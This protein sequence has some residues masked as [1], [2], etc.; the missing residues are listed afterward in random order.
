MKNF[1]E[2]VSNFWF[3]ISASDEYLRDLCDHMPESKYKLQGAIELIINICFS[4]CY[5][6]I[7][8]DDNGRYILILS[9]SCN[10][11]NVL[12]IRYLLNQAPKELH[13]HWDFY[14]GFPKTNNPNY[15][16]E[17]KG[18]QFGFHDLYIYPKINQ[19]FMDFEVY[20]ENFQHLDYRM[21]IYVT[22]D[23]MQA[24]LGEIDLIYLVKHVKISQEKLTDSFPLDQLPTYIKNVIQKEQWFNTENPFQVYKPYS[25]I[26]R[27]ND[28]DLRDDMYYGYSTQIKLMNE[29]FDFDDHQIQAAKENGI[30]VGFIFYEHTRISRNKREALREELEDKITE[31]CERKQIAEN[32]GIAGGVYYSY[33]DYVV[34]DWECFTEVMSEFLADVDTA[35]YGFHYFASK[36]KPFYMVN[37]AVDNIN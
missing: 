11:L 20:A 25:T 33:I 37:K 29:V 31:A 10:P 12:Y 28:T 1:K 16:I 32:I 2:R 19:G 9:P 3:A 7:K 34:Y 22:Y 17:A 24:C 15:V 6:D 18:Y 4:K 26:P 5:Y 30:T 23:L 36:E 13:E 8:K 21:K 14:C 35:V 27:T